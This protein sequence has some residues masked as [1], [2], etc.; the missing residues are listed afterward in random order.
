M[1]AVAGLVTAFCLLLTAN[2]H[3]QS[4]PSKPVRVVVPYA[5][6]GANDLLGRVFAEKLSKAFGQQFFV[7]NR[8]GGGG[9]IGTEAVARS[10]PDGTTLMISGMPSHVLGPAMNKTTGFDPIKD[11]THIAYLGGPPNV[12]VVNAGTDIKTFKELLDLMRSK[13]GG[14]EYVSPSIGS[15]GNTVAEYMAAKEKVKLVHVTYRGGGAAILDLVAG[16]VKVGSMTA[17]TTRP[18]ILAG[19]LRPLAI[20]S[21]RRVPEFPDVPTLVEL[22][23]PELV[24]TTWYSLSGP[25]KLPR[26][27]VEKLNREVNSAMSDPEV[28]KHLDQE[29]VQ[30]RAMSP[31]EMTAFM[32]SEV[33]K[34]VPAV[35][36]T[37]DVK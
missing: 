27:I 13:P 6:G 17:S 10:E 15:V 33:D 28:K 12:F 14:V 1:K 26:D 34:W 16:H 11:F 32:Q 21:A 5:A 23:Y 9:M 31:E 2:A 36:K 22:G 20:S 29:M 37:I 24:V 19:K 18:H 3:A 30:T 35:R 7:E 25:A 4:W 8:T